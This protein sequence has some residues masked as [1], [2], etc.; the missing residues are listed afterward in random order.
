MCHLTCITIMSSPSGYT[1]KTRS[2]LYVT[3]VVF[4][5]GGARRVTVLTVYTGISTTC[6]KYKSNVHLIID[7]VKY[8]LNPWKLWY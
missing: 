2:I 6:V 1:R 5:V 4:T 7:N 8:A 3:C